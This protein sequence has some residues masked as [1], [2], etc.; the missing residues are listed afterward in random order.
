MKGTTAFLAFVGLMVPFGRTLAANSNQPVIPSVEFSTTILP[1]TW[2]QQSFKRN[3]GLAFPKVLAEFYVRGDSYARELGSWGS[4]SIETLAARIT[5]L[6]E[7]ALWDG[8]SRGQLTF[9]RLQKFLWITP[10]ERGSSLAGYWR[11]QILAVTHED[12]RRLTQAFLSVCA[13]SISKWRAEQLAKLENEIN[14]EHE[15]LREK[16]SALSGALTD[17]ATVES[18]YGPIKNSDRYRARTDDD[19]A[20]AAKMTI[21]RMDADTDEIEIRTTEIRAK[22]EMID[23]YRQLNHANIS[24]KLRLM[25]VESTIELTGLT[26]RREAIMKITTAAKDLSQHYLRRQ[27]LIAHIHKLQRDMRRQQGG[28]ENGEEELSRRAGEEPFEA[29][30]EYATIRPLKLQY[31]D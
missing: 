7:I 10:A 24:D 22:L 4:L 19:A 3:S 16:E 23:K 29:F 27:T 13:R 9:C 20:E 1:M 25:E 11:V 31:S 18:A 14:G 28:I 30:Q 6:R 17:L 21:Q 12:A 8:L 5:V 26:A 15:S 2:S